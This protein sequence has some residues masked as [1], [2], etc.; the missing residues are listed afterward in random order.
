MPTITLSLSPL[1]NGT[2]RAT[3]RATFI[4]N[5]TNTIVTQTPITATVT[6]GAGTIVLEQ[7]SHVSVSYLFELF[8]TSTTIFDFYYQNGALYTSTDVL[9]P[10]PF[11]QWTTGGTPDNQY[12]TGSQVGTT[13]PVTT[14]SNPNIRLTRIARNIQLIQPFDSVIGATDANFST[15][16][17]IGFTD[18]QLS[19]S[20]TRV[21]DLLTQAPYIT[22]LP[23]GITYKNAYVGA[24]VYS[25]DQAVQY[26]GNLYVYINASSV[27]GKTPGIDTAYWDLAVSKGSSG[28]TGANAIGYNRTQWLTSPF[29]VE[30]SARKDIVAA[31]DGL[32]TPDLSAYASKAGNNDYTGLNR[33]QAP[34]G[35]P[36]SLQPITYGYAE[37]RYEKLTT[38]QT[39]A[40][41]KTYSNSPI[42]PTLAGSDNTTKVANTAQ[43][44]SALSLFVPNRL[45]TLV[46][47]V[48]RNSVQAFT[49]NNP[50]NIV[51]NTFTVTGGWDTGGGYAVPVTGNYMIFCKLKPSLAT[52]NFTSTD[53]AITRAYWNRSSPSSVDVGNFFEE[54][55]NGISTGAALSFTKDGWWYGAMTAGEIYSLQILCSG[56]A[57]SSTANAQS[58]G[59]GGLSNNRI[60][61]WRVN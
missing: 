52:V 26:N 33:F 44:Q 28:G 5:G 39:I 37:G 8:Q 61:I 48:Q 15:L 40:G 17:D 38:D 56:S 10:L 49:V 16:I 45:S 50:T 19:Y 60:I 20:I 13:P 14:G 55:M 29:D 35:S 23:K 51:W 7:S 59:N 46:A 58:I 6:S 54:N 41:I 27:A 32:A 18:N 31:L 57:F 22:L 4:K 53:R 30:A 25:R 36:D 3:P 43:V 1:L 11:F 47:D 2:L 24:T 12:Y 21:A 9:T 34:G 42:V